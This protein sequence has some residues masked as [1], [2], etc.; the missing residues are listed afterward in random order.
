[1]DRPSSRKPGTAV[2]FAALALA[3]ALW[4]TPF[5]LAKWIQ[6]DL[7]VGH[8]ILL[9]FAFAS[10]ALVPVVLYERRTVSFHVQRRDVPVF[11]IAALLGVPVQF[12]IQF[13]GLARTT[14]SHASLMIGM[15]P[16]ILA[17]GAV[18]F[19]KEHLDRA[20]VLALAA[21]S[22]GAALVAV[23]G[24]GSTP[25]DASILG[26]SL[27]LISLF[28]GAAWVLLSQRLMK[29]GYSPIVTT[30]IVIISGTM[31]LAVWMLFTEGLPDLMHLS[32]R[33]WI[34]VALMGVTATALT[35][36]LWNWGLARVAASQAGVFVNLE[37]VVG[38]ILGIALFHDHIAVLGLLGGSLIVASA[39]A[40]AR[41]G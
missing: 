36:L 12:I 28:G 22:I 32:P 24:R 15:L 26:D 21:S 3:G 14:V 33:V 20:G 19:A 37:P 9:R 25:T 38:T 2:G 40:V 41:R 13:E 16:V 35:T 39:I 7:S 30:S 27:V 23:G 29:R 5:A 1:M 17:V 31:M 11:A 18:I 10:L 8:M 34:S 4:G 6:A